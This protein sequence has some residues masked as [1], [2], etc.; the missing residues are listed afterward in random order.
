MFPTPDPTIEEL[1]T[2]SIIS[3]ATKSRAQ[4]AEI[5][6][7]PNDQELVQQCDFIL[8]IVPPRDAITT[9]ERISK[10]ATSTGNS[11]LLFY[12]D[13]NATSPRTARH[14][15]TILDSN[16]NIR[17]LDGGIIGGVPFPKESST[18]KPEWHCPNLI[19]SGP[20]RLPDKNL[21]EILNVHHLGD[22]IGTA[23]GLKMCFGITTKGFTAL[24]IEAFTT[25]HRLGVLSELQDYLGKYNPSTLQLA[26]K[27]LVTMPPKAYRWVHEMLEMAD[28]A[29]EDGG[30][31][32]EL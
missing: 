12:L 28:T 16:P 2:P 21:A 19:V 3:E 26:E 27:G 15:A 8:S 4:A 11:R 7:L 30:F 1:L 29:T 17:F 5:E 32:R 25:A 18:K 9:A 20:A 10:A 24:A 22:S 14:I 23:T 31:E 13:I 6:L